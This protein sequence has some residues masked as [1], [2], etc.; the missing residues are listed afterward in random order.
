[1][2]WIIFKAWIT[3]RKLVVLTGDDGKCYLTLERTDLN[4]KKYAH[5]YDRWKIGHV[6]LIEGQRPMGETH[7]IASWRYYK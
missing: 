3:C 7:Y 1:M 2:I 4:G 5:V 6:I